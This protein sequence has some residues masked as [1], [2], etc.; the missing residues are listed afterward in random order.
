MSQQNPHVLQLHDWHAA[1]A[2]MLYWD[3]YN[4]NGFR[5]VRDVFGGTSGIQFKPR[6]HVFVRLPVTSR[7]C[8][9]H[10]VVQATSKQRCL[11]PDAAVLRLQSHAPDAHHPQPGQHR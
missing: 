4:P 11:T 7:S 6:H 3:V 2:S 1:A 9:M 5:C 8:N 10:C